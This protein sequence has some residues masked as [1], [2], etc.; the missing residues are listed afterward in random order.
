MGQLDGKHLKKFRR[1]FRKEEY[2]RRSNVDS[3]VIAMWI[4]A[5]RCS[6]A[7]AGSIYKL[8]GA[9]W[10]VIITIYTTL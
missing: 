5:L 10:L 4:P 6:L 1:W 7:A 3:L 8:G 9:G 2:R